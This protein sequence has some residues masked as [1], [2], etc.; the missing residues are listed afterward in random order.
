MS[1]AD[2]N[3]E[4]Y[5]YR[6]DRDKIRLIRLYI[7]DHFSDVKSIKAVLDDA[8]DEWMRKRDSYFRSVGK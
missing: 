6:I 8:L 4:Q 7:A 5:S 2:R 1:N 3:E